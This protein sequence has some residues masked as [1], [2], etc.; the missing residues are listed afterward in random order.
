MT[1]NE[2]FLKD[3][4][5]LK[6]EKEINYIDAVIEWCDNNEIEIDVIAE[7]IKKDIMLRSKIQFEAENLNY[8][9]KGNRLPI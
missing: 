9:K 7:Y 4:E 8:I 1:N 6:K 2:A 3:I 5:V